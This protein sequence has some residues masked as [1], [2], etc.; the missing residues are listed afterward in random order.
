MGILGVSLLSR[1]IYVR[2]WR[3]RTGPRE[4]LDSDA[5]EASIV[6]PPGTGAPQSLVSWGQV[7][8]LCY[9]LGTVIRSSC[10]QAGTWTLGEMTPEG[11]SYS[12]GETQLPT[13]LEDGEWV[14]P[15]RGAIWPAQHSTHRAG[16]AR[17]GLSILLSV[18]IV[19]T[20]SETVAGRHAPSQSHLNSWQPRKQPSHFRTS[21]ALTQHLHHWHVR[22]NRRNGNSRWA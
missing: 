22:R 1:I 14:C 6:A 13:L 5:A 17:V 7:P 21:N 18:T 4:K 11:Q 12:W 9:L 15:S 3:S 20:M 16:T 10:P 2:E 8:G 19:I